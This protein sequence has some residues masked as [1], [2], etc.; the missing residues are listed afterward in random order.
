MAMPNGVELVRCV[1]FGSCYN[2]GLNV[3]VLVANQVVMLIALHI[4]SKLKFQE[5]VGDRMHKLGN[6]LHSAPH[7]NQQGGAMNAGIG[8]AIGAH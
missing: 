5:L 6:L 2:V 3:G 1:L 7:G 8:M 4:L